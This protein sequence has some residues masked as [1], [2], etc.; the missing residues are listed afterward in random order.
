[1]VYIGLSAF[2]GFFFSKSMCMYCGVDCDDGA[3]ACPA[4]QD[5]GVRRMGR[6][7]RR[8]RRAARLRKGKERRAAKA[9]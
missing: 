7:R 5:P 2:D 1:M 3:W 6:R 9:R 4:G 8:R